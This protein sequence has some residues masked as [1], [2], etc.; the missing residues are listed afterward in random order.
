LISCQNVTGSDT[1]YCCD[2]QNGPCCENGVG[3]F[4][5][6]PPHPSTSATYNNQASRYDVLPPTSK[7][8][9]TQST[10]A[11][12]TAGPKT[13]GGDGQSPANQNGGPTGTG[14]DTA[15]PTEKPSEGLSSS[16]SAGIG[17]GVGLGVA[18]L[19]VA[20]YL[21]WRRYRKNKASREF[22]Q[23]APSGPY[24]VA[25]GMPQHQP[26][27]DYYKQQPQPQPQPQ[28]QPSP[29]QEMAS[30]TYFHELGPSQGPRREY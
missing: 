16:A 26:V 14:S 20:S 19:A 18:A 17:V 2:H 5:V 3:R 29:P 23:G 28:W 24:G 12:S 4:N 6:M 8:S 13:T 11:S 10:S 27:A 1:S 30:D 22:A 15:Q 21:L 7:P 9:P 25:S